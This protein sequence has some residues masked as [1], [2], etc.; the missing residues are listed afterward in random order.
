[1]Y[2]LPPSATLLLFRIGWRRARVTGGRVGS[3]L[4][5]LLRLQYV[6]QSFGFVN[7]SSLWSV[8]AA[9]RA[10]LLFLIT[11]IIVPIILVIAVVIVHQW[12]LQ[13]GGRT[14]WCGC[15]GD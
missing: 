7:C 15:C 13:R 3:Q 4:R 2:V 11:V 12:T 9:V 6:N 8:T 14:A 1:M 10:L 5:H